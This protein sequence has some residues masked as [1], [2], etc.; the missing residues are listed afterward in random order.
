MLA[1][2]FRV[3]SLRAMLLNEAIQTGLLLVR[4]AV[5]VTEVSALAG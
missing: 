1:L 5:A 2:S 3:P 4:R